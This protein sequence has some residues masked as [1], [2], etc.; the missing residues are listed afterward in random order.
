MKCP[1]CGYENDDNTSHCSQCQ[2]VIKESKSAPSASNSN[3]PNKRFSLG[4]IL[5]IIC[6][7]V[8]VGVGAAA[9]YYQS[10]SATIQVTLER[11]SD[12]SVSSHYVLSL[13][14]D[15]YAE[16]D[17]APGESRVIQIEVSFPYNAAA[18]MQIVSASST[19]HSLD[20][21]TIVVSNG[22]IYP[23]HFFV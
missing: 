15:K 14:G 19:D 20:Q 1:K 13:N 23:I 4:V 8:G 5:I 17:M 2:T 16:G 18:A 6:I 7:L 21:R 12:Y 3:Q 9:F 10:H 11:I 22:G